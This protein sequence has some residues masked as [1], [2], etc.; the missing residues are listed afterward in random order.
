VALSHRPHDGE[1]QCRS[2]EIFSPSPT[3]TRHDGPDMDKSGFD[4]QILALL[5]VV[6]GH[7]GD[8]DWSPTRAL[9]ESR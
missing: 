9:R 1:L 6:G 4:G 2:S 8:L 3:L 7:V 5:P